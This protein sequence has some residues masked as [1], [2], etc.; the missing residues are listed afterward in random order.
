LDKIDAARRLAEPDYFELTCGHLVPVRWSK[1]C[2]I[3]SFDRRDASAFPRVVEDKPFVMHVFVQTTRGRWSFHGKRGRQEVDAGTLVTGLKGDHYGCAHDRHDGDSN[4]I[5]GLR[6]D[7]VD[8]GLPL[9][10]RDALALDLRAPLERALA[11]E[12]P[13]RFES[14]IFEMFNLVSNRSLGESRVRQS[15]GLRMQRVKRFIEDHAFE[16]LG[17]DAIAAS[18]NLSPFT[19]LRQFKLHVGMTPHTYLAQLRLERARELLRGSAC[20]VAEVGR[21]IGMRDQCY[22]SRWFAKEA[23]ITPSRFRRDSR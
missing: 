19:C 21:A 15:N 16:D 20:D 8:D 17:L 11:S 3:Y 18:V 22:F 10:E 12:D 6:A 13:D 14:L 9:F 23:G 1:Y 7:A 5:A 4:L 2:A